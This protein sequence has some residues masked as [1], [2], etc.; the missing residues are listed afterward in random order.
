MTLLSSLRKLSNTNILS[1]NFSSETTIDAII[2]G[3]NS[4][5]VFKKS[6]L[7]E[8]YVPNIAGSWLVIFCDEINIPRPD[9]YG[10]QEVISFLRQLT[11]KQGFWKS[12]NTW[13]T[14]K[15][16]Q[17]IGACNPPTDSGR[18]QL[19]SRFTRHCPVIYVDYPSSESLDSIYGTLIEA[20]LK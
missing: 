12:N 17:V 4:H 9:R 6:S 14:V 18:F 13:V 16:V 19:D 1:L 8:V 5:G 7:G 20:I 3:L 2:S 11:E 15:N 10:T